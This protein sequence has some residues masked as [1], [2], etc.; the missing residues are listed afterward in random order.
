MAEEPK[1][2]PHS[3]ESAFS[4]QI[5]LKEKRKLRAVRHAGRGI[6]FGLGTIGVIGWSVALPSV[7]GAV[8]GIWLD[9]R[10]PGR[11]SWTLMLIII[12]IAFGCWNAAYWVARQQKEIQKEQEDG[13]HE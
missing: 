11:Y 8:L 12:G 5:G 2:G 9:R 6:W 1:N 10:Y 4:R 13:R 3:H 7:L